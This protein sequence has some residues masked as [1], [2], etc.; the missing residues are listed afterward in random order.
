MDLEALKTVALVARHG[1]FAAVSRVL[2]VDPSSVSRLVAGVETEL[3]LRLFQRT[4]RT[5]SVTEEGAAYLARIEPLLEEFDHAQDMAR[6]AARQPA[7]TLR[8]TASVAFAHECIVPHLGSFTAKYPEMALELLPTD[9]N[10]DLA[11]NAIDLAIRL[12][13]M[14]SGDV[15][16]TRLMS[17]RYVVCAAPEYLAAHPKLESPTDLANHPCLRFALPH[18]RMRWRFRRPG[19]DPVEVD[20]SGP[21]IIANALSLRRA[22]VAG[23][24]P[25]LLADWLIA[26]DLAEGRLVSVFPDWDCTATEFDT[27]AW[28]LYPSRTYLPQK[29]RV[30]IDFLRGKLS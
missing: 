19:S 20:V 4:T 15:I 28:A 6:D 18:Y 24:G 12:A 21:M 13:P 2:D 26:S 1:S 22:T 9:A 3:G 27:A 8:M 30:M 29:V 14:P 25:A 10:M 17:T 5:L 7:G 16:S 23:F 11:G